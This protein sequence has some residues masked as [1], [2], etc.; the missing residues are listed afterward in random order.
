MKTFTKLSKLAAT[1]ASVGAITLLLAGN[2]AAFTDG[3]ISGGD[4]YR[5]EDLTQGTA[6]ADTINSNAGDLLEYRVRLYNP[7]SAT[8]T[9]V[10]VEAT[11]TNEVV[12]SNESTITASAANADPST[13]TAFATVNFTSPESESLVSGTTQLLDQ[14]DNFVSTLP[15][16]ITTSGT[17][18]TVGQ[19]GP[20]VIE[21][22]QFQEKV[23]SPTTPPP[24]PAYTCDKLVVAT[25]DNRTV[26]IDTFQTTATN[27]ATF[28]SADI[29]WGDNS[30]ANDN[31][32]VVGLS[33]QYAA[34]GT[35][36][37]SATA[38]FSVAGKDVT[39]GGA[40]CEQVVT[41]S[42][43]TPPTVTPPTTPAPT[44]PAPTALV[45]TGAGNVFGLFAVVSL[46]GAGFY[47]F[48]LKRKLDSR[49]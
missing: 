19:I 17:G 21:Y 44:T 34:S 31:T 33:H 18:V 22:V 23:S 36:T 20:S 38:H 15:D 25:E 41:F 13:T 37:I 30:T 43:T 10:R 3:Q 16:T 9:N 27:G 32:N 49:I 35:Y 8:L 46:A 1:I 42:T 47:R 6:F 29:N 26:K 40:S 48:V 24:T 12:T 11:I 7:G 14:N 5:V 2:A 45:N 4:I 39:A 28:T